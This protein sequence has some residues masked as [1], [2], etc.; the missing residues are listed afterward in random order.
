M[1]TNQEGRLAAVRA[2]TGTAY[3][4]NG[5]WIALFDHESIAAGKF[6]ERLLAWINH[7]LGTSYASLPQAQEAYAA[8]HGFTRWSD[9]NTIGASG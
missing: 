6:N 4:Y 9:I 8:A 3:G 2:I 5:D 7:R 1:S